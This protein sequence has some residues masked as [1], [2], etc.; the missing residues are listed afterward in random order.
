MVTYTSL[1]WRINEKVDFGRHVKGRQKWIRDREQVWTNN[2]AL[3]SFL[4]LA[5]SSYIVK[6]I[7]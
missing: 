5:S 3:L 6:K 7:Y 4:S 1:V 2:Q